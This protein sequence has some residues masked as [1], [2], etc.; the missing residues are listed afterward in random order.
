MSDESF[1]SQ[2]Q[3][4]QQHLGFINDIGR[5]L[6]GDAYGLGGTRADALTDRFPGLQALL[7]SLAAASRTARKV[8]DRLIEDWNPLSQRVL[9][10]D[11]DPPE[12]TAFERDFTLITS[13]VTT[14]VEWGH[15]SI[16]V[17]AMEPWLCGWREISAQADFTDWNLASEALA[18]WYADIVM[19]GAIRR[20][21]P[22]ADLV[23]TRSSVSNSGFHPEQ[24]FR[25]I[26]LTDPDELVRLYVDAFLGQDTPL[27]SRTHPF[28]GTLARRLRDFYV[29]T[30]ST[31]DNLYTILE[32]FQ[33]FD[34]F[35]GRFCAVEGLPSMFDDDVLRTMAGCRLDDYVVRLGTEWLPRLKHL[36]PQR[37]EQVCA[38]RH[39]QTRAYYAWMLRK[40]VEKNWVFAL[41]GPL[42]A[43]AL[44]AGLTA[45]LDGLEAA[46]RALARGEPPEAAMA[47]LRL[48]DCDYETGVRRPLE[49]SAAHVK[50]R[51]HLYPYFAPSGG[52]IGIRDGR[53]ALSPAEMIEVARFVMKRCAWTGPFDDD[54]L[55]GRLHAF[56]GA[57]ESASLDDVG[58]AF[59]HFMI[60]PAALH[61]WSVRLA[62][63]HPGENRYREFAF[64]YT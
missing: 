48:L 35:Y 5:R 43:E 46:L 60:H 36:P 31:L 15:E 8:G 41:N 27:Q 23:Y 14:F 24:A 51:Y 40:A 38:R 20:H 34:G 63:L 50:Y 1:T 45:Y 22:E 10:S 29:G 49:E 21:V 3:I 30:Q 62:D 56:L 39:I 59:N 2:A 12:A 58:T 42:G 64:E 16:H 32:T 28:P 26:G 52:I 7:N 54:G 37:I 19:I 53:S 17:L 57:T 13:H 9:L 6:R 47:R 25:Q 11:E 61:V 4:V 44:I 55:I 33:L 18:F